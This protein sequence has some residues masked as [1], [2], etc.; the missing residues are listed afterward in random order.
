[1]PTYNEANLLE[2]IS[3]NLRGSRRGHAVRHQYRLQR[4]GPAHVRQYANGA[5]AHYGYD[6]LI[7]T[8]RLYTRR[9]RR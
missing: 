3:V 7:S 1:M 4:Q 6:P 8:V 5:E 9:A 2:T